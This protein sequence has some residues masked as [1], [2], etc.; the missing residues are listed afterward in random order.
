MLQEIL[1]LSTVGAAAFFTIRSI[2]R[3]I[4]APQGNVAGCS[5]CSSAS[6]CQIKD[7]K[8]AAIK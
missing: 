6:G 3:T 2:Y 1:A 5:G 7:L 8:S 4:T